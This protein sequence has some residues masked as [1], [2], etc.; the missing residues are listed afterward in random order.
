MG[1]LKACGWHH[2]VSAAATPG[3]RADTTRCRIRNTSIAKFCLLRTPGLLWFSCI[4][5]RSSWIQLSYVTLLGFC[6]ALTQKQALWISDAPRSE[7]HTSELQSL[8]RISYAA[9]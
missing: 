3:V 5:L 2:G 9:F 8:M 4:I 1:R 6:S 7:E